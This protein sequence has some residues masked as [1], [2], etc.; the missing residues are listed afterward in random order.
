MPLQ[1]VIYTI[2][3]E[4]KVEITVEGV[5][6]NSCKELTLRVEQQLGEVQSVEFKSEYYERTETA[7]DHTIAGDSIYK[8]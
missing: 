5:K 4:G 3:P 8:P 7:E 1:S 6:G 2:S